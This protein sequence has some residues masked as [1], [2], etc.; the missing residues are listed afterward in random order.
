MKIR[1]RT[2]SP[3]WY[4]GT[5]EE[6]RETIA[7]Y[8]REVP[9]R[10]AR[11]VAG[12]APHAGWFFSGKIA[13]QVFRQL[14]SDTDTIVVVGGHLHAGDGVLS[15]LE[16]GY[17]TPLGPLAADLELLDRVRQEVP[18]EEDIYEDNTVEVQLPFVKY[19]FPD[20]RA[21]AMRAAPSASAIGLGKGIKAAAAALGRKV[22]VVGSTDLTHYGRNYGFSPA[23]RGEA[24]LKWVKEVNDR[25]FIDSLLAMNAEDALRHARES[26]S[27][28]SAGGAVAAM[29]FAG[30]SGIEGGE[31]LCYMTSYDVHPG[32]SFVGYAG[33]SYDG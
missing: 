14:K 8:L 29:T 3:G 26:G 20:A 33:I 6:T 1:P 12:V 27:A 24:A 15:A 2:L 10:R 7:Q 19:L 30:E 31:L 5:G 4:P 25:A 13:L 17:E 11:G 22:A 28:C 21:L 32:E 16:D 9:E 18:V 23:G